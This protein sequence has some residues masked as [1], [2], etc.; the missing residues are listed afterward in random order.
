MARI[1]KNKSGRMPVGSADAGTFIRIAEQET[2]K[3]GGGTWI[4]LAAFVLFLFDLLTDYRGFNITDL[5]E[6]SGLLKFL[7]SLA[8]IAGIIVFFYFM[9]SKYKSPQVIISFAFVAVLGIITLALLIN[10]DWLPVVHFIYIL[11]FWLTFLR[12]REDAASANW[13]LVIVM[14]FDLYFLSIIN[15]FAPAASVWL[16][17]IPFLFFLTLGYVAEQTNNKLSTT[18][19][20]LIVVWYFLTSGPALA[21]GLGAA[22]IQGIPTQIP[23]SLDSIKEKFFLNPLEKL[24]KG[25][26]AW[27]NRQITYAVT[28]KV[29]E[30][31]KEPVGVYIDSF[32]PAEPNFYDDEEVIFWGLLRVRT[33]DDP[34]I[35]NAGCYLKKSDT[36]SDSKNQRANKVDPGKPFIVY[37]LEERDFA[38]TFNRGTLST[39]TTTITAFSEFNFETEAKQKVYFIHKDTLRSMLSPTVKIDPFADSKITD[40]VPIARYTNGPIKIEMGVLSS[41]DKGTLVGVG[42]DANPASAT[43]NIKNNDGWKG[44]I[45]QLEE[46]VILAP[47]GVAFQD[48][49][50][51]K[52]AD[53]KYT[54]EDCE[55]DTANF[56]NRRCSNACSGEDRENCNRLC[57]EK[58]TQSKEACTELFSAEEKEDYQGYKVLLDNRDR[59]TT[60]GLFKTL[61]CRFTATDEVL[62]GPGITTKFL[63]VKTRYDYRVEKQASVKIGRF[64]ELGKEISGPIKAS[65]KRVLPSD[66]D[67]ETKKMVIELANAFGPPANIPPSIIIAVAEKESNFRHCISGGPYDCTIDKKD[68]ILSNPKGD[69]WGV[70][71]ISKK[72]RANPGAF[73]AST[74]TEFGCSYG[75]TAYEFDCNVKAGITVLKRGLR[76]LDDDVYRKAVMANCGS[77]STPSLD[78]Q[79]YLTR[80]L[81]YKDWERVLRSYNGLGCDTSEGHDVNYVENMKDAIAKYDQLAEAEQQ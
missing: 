28:G 14:F 60:E 10:I 23:T 34:V 75:Q 21:Q 76:Y 31:E 64:D 74:S 45:R 8:F 44:G 22:G 6:V 1:L 50:G 47:K 18:L 13:K 54:R 33:L 56:I 20:I 37:T 69:A 58:I 81:G 25:S 11:V 72:P 79:Q 51:C 38:C 40:R 39:G 41:Y 9:V 70:M 73:E 78:Q 24:S 80:Y 12:Q 2:S 4:T 67:E 32:K 3:K 53:A 55:I 29:E 35:L 63:K 62:Q 42:S 57:Q 71:Q 7:G 30:Y 59:A 77:P 46:V 43:I 65:L 61:T 36:F 66:T 49:P 17:G 52:F 5:G 48:A 16:E 68:N 27:L 19:I 26:S 15:I